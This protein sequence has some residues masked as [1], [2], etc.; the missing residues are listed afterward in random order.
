MVATM[1]IFEQLQSILKAQRAHG[2]TNQEIAERVGLSQAHVNRL[3]NGSPNVIA[4]VKFGTIL[5]LFP[6]IIC[7]KEPNDGQ[8]SQ[9]NSPGAAASIGG[10]AVATFSAKS[11]VKQELLSMILDNNELDDASKVKFLKVLKALN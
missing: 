9:N 11:S 8:I 6:G 2:T 4:S 1:T 5:K 10:D 7:L 3:L